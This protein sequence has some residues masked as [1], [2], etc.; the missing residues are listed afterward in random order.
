MAPFPWHATLRYGT[1]VY[2]LVHGNGATS[3]AVVRHKALFYGVWD[4]AGGFGAGGF[5]K[6]LSYDSTS[7]SWTQVSPA[8]ANNPTAVVV[9]GKALFAGGSF[10][11]SGLADVDI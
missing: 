9:N 4:G 8:S 3:V 6:Y 2:N 1:L 5:V 10:G 7:D 11:S